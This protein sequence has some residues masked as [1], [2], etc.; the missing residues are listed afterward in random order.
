MARILICDP[1]DPTGVA[2]LRE[3]GHEV[4][5]LNADEK[6]DI[7]QHATGAEAFVV[8]SGTRVTAELMDA[9][10]E[11]LRV[12]GRA[13]VG[14]DNV[15]IKAATERGILVVNAPTANLLSATE[16]TFA[17]LLGLLRRV[18]AADRALKDARWDRKSFVGS[19]L[20]GKTLGIVGFGRIGQ[21]VARRARAFEMKVVAYDPFLD[22]DAIRRHEVEPLSLEDLLATADAVTLHV[23]KTEGTANLI[24]ADR[25]ATMKPTAVLVN[26]ARGGIVDED[27]LLAALESGAL[28]GAGLDVFEEEPPTSFALSA[29]PKVVATP[30]VGAQTRE[31]QLRIAEDTARMVDRALAGSLAVT[32]VNLPFRPAGSQGEPFLALAETL[33]RLASHLLDDGIRRI[34][35]ALHGVE[36]ALHVPVS[37]AAL[38]GALSPF[39]EGINVVNASRIAEDRGIEIVRAVHE[40]PAA[41][42]F[43]IEVRLSAGTRG[44]ELA[45]TL[46]HGHD[47]RV[48]RLD[49]HLL[50]FSPKGALLVVR[51][52][53]VP[54]VVGSL[55]T[56]LGAAGINIA[57]IHLSRVSGGGEAL[58]VVRLDTRPPASVVEK[59]ADLGPV[60]EV[61]VV[62]V[63]DAETT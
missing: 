63:G 22:A 54:G 7:L 48:I 25:L 18:P 62:D 31:A 42:L 6:P 3:L 47:P 13:G 38:R 30:H 11:S 1:L 57:A 19:E 27:A 50:E 43:K 15:D 39:V 53:D 32:A 4:R 23:P 5:E 28:A 40:R 59:L 61:R 52:D 29:H 33:G 60:R 58:A 46:V 36:D 20:W 51:N 41:H 8:R 21:K 55:G 2:L 14:V 26:C 44:V 17:L 34:E 16:H 35:V 37:I 45:G 24:D 9:A 10:G 49:D 12:I 56:A